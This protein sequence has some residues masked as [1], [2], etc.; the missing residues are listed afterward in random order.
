[1][2]VSIS[3]E[4]VISRLIIEYTN[5]IDDEPPLKDMIYLNLPQLP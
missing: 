4:R 1:M 5:T 2:Y 3:T